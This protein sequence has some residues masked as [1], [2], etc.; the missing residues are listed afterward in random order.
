MFRARTSAPWWR[1]RALV[2]LFFCAA[3]WSL[4]AIGADHVEAAPAA[5]TVLTQEQPDGT[6]FRARQYGDEWEHGLE[7]TDGYTI[8]QEPGTGVWQYA[9][10]GAGGRLRAN[11]KVV[12]RDRPGALPR[13]VRDGVGER[14][15]AARAAAAPTPEPVQLSPMVGAFTPSLTTPTTTHRNLVILAEFTDQAS[16]GTTPAQWSDRFFGPSGSLKDYYEE[17][18]YGQFTVL[19]AAETHGVAADGVVGWIPIGFDH[20]YPENVADPDEDTRAVKAAIQAADPFVDYEAYDVDDDGWV[21]P[22]ELHITVIAAGY[23]GSYDD[24]APSMWGHRYCLCINNAWAPV[25]ADNN[26]R[27]GVG[28]TAFGEMHNDHQATLGIVAHEFGHDIGWPDLYDTEGD[29][30][31]VGA[32]SLMA[33]GT[34]GRAPGQSHDGMSP[35]HPDAWL[36][37]VQGWTDP[38]PVYGTVA[39]AAIAQATSASPNDVA[40]R[41][42]N[43]PGGTEDWN[44]EGEGSGEYFLVENRRPTPGSYDAS[45]PGGGLLIWHINEAQ[46]DNDTNANRLVA[47]EQADALRELD[48]TMALADAG[49]PYGSSANRVFGPASLPSSA[50]NDGSASGFSVVNISDLAA[51]MTAD[52]TGPARADLSVS[53]TATAVHANVSWLATVA[54]AGPSTADD[55]VLTESLPTGLSAVSATASQGSCVVAAVVTCSIG[56]VLPGAT[57][58]VGIEAV[59]EHTGAWTATAAV[60]TA[61]DDPTLGNDTATTTAT[62]DRLVATADLTVSVDAVKPRPSR[63]FSYVVTV[64]NAGDDV[65][66]SAALAFRLPGGA[67][68]RTVMGAS[69]TGSLVLACALGTV[70]PGEDVSVRVIAR[71][72]T[73]NP[74]TG[75][76]TVTT[77]SAEL[78]SPNNT[79]SAVATPQLLCDNDA[80]AGNDVI[81]GTSSSEMLCGLSGDDVLIGASGSDLLFGGAG[82]DT[83][84]YSGAPDPVVVDLGRQGL[85]GYAAAP[86]LRG[87]TAHGKDHLFSIEHVAGSNFADVLTGNSAGNVL[88]GLGGGDTLWGQGGTDT[89]YGGRGDDSLYGGSG[90]DTLYGGLGGDLCRS[91]SDQQRSCER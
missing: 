22:D 25:V 44:W 68:L 86:R 33:Y 2:L 31:A 72:A 84:S 26:T 55:V 52:V 35:S 11:G 60:A 73:S 47:L 4:G 66:E 83:A 34:W 81:V 59:A 12:G 27:V 74:L 49:D 21:S 41:V 20:P 38:T 75:R 8:V 43:N 80:T 78:P 36:K 57:P 61:T 67:Q 82:A 32:W 87:T 5:P 79:A 17:V 9:T 18:S 13:H 89:I 48:L 88:R 16:L 14:E 3:A 90:A 56:D 50:F 10:R 46:G 1:Q 28:Y 85:D 29:T 39:G 54:N 71:P 15:G 65:A 76:A 53:Q 37:Y 77:T 45:L 19:P 23:E 6:T 70:D 30:A 40:L 7:T 51:T 58:T 42:G 64:S 91:V 69:C 63:D 24:S 62:V